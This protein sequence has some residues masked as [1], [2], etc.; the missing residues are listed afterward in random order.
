MEIENYQQEYEI[1]RLSCDWENYHNI[2]RN[3]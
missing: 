3:E 2:G 1:L